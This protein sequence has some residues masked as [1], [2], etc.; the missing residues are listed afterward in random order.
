MPS[1]FSKGVPEYP[2]VAI[3]FNYSQSINTY[4]HSIHINISVKNRS[5]IIAGLSFSDVDK[6]VLHKNVV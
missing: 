1:F 2:A 4:S 3:I 6:K 5:K